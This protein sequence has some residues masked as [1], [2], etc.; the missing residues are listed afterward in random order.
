[1]REKPSASVRSLG[2]TTSYEIRT[3][4]EATL[5]AIGPNQRLVTYMGTGH[6]VEFR[7]GEK[8]QTVAEAFDLKHQMT[9]TRYPQ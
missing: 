4:T 2:N 1:M 9:F 5:T 7:P 8:A 6:L 3:D